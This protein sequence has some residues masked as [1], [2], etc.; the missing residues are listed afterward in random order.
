MT[1][2]AAPE[3]LVLGY[4]KYQHLVDSVE[5]IESIEVDWENGC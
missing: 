4:F 2:G 3:A 1:L 5:D